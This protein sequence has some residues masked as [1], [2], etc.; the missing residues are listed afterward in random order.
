M[1][2][3]AVSPLSLKDMVLLIGTDSYEKHVSKVQLVP[4]VTKKTWR[5]GTP[6]AV[7]TDVS[8]AT[9]ECQIDYVQDW[10]TASSLSQ[11]LLDNE[12][13]TKAAVFTPANGVGKQFA[14]NLVITPGA[15]GGTI[16][17]YGTTSVSLGCDKP[18]ATA[19][20]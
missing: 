2:Q 10:E 12:G 18:V 6:D 20:I 17:D 5:G 16:G 9:W 4:S 13:L 7:F 1:A 14:V 3:I 8:T 15:V 19:V 11:Y